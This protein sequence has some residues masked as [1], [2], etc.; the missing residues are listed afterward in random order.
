MSS[1][2]S[3]ITLTFTFERIQKMGCCP[4]SFLLCCGTFDEALKL[5][6]IYVCFNFDQKN[7]GSR[8]CYGYN[9]FFCV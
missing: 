1:E 5:C 2:Y 3:P 7:S 6:Y 4:G 8:F 9:T